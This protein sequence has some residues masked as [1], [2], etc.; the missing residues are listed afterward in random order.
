MAVDQRSGNV[1]E[2]VDRGTAY[3]SKLQAMAHEHNKS[4]SPHRYS[5]DGGSSGSSGGAGSLPKMALS[6]DANF[7]MLPHVNPQEVL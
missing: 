6:S 3:Q 4:H 5:P 1:S 2:L 7:Q